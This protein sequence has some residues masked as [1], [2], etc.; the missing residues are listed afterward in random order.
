MSSRRYPIPWL[1]LGVGLIVL[2]ALPGLLWIV[3]FASYVGVNL[4]KYGHHQ[5]FAA[6]SADM[7]EPAR[8]MDELFADCRHYI[9]YGPQNVPLFN[10]VAYFGDRYQLLMQVEVQ[11]D[12]DQSGRATGEPKFILWE[13]GRIDVAPSGVMSYSYANQ[14]EISAAQWR[15][16][17]DHQGDFGPI[18]ITLNPA[19]VAHFQEFTAAER[20]SN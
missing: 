11:I 3:W 8:Q 14:Y 12:S 5:D 2:L 15:K 16:I 1:P 6:R 9:T 17:Y 13:L 19:P 4:Y 18:G 20:P 10:S 7:I